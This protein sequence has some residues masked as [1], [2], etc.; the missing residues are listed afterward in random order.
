MSASNIPG[1]SFAALFL[2]TCQSAASVTPAQNCPYH[3]THSM[4]LAMTS[5]DYPLLSVAQK[6]QGSVLLD[7]LVK[8]DGSIADVK[9]AKSSGFALLDGAAVD[10]AGQRWRFDPVMLE[11]KPI[12][13][14]AKVEVVWKLDQSPEELVSAGFALV[15]LSASDFPAGSPALKES[16]AAAIIVLV[17][18]DGTVRDVHCTQSSGFRDLDS[19]AIEAARKGGWRYGA[20]QV[21]GK[22][23]K[24]LVGIVAMWSP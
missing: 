13:C 12:A 9:V 6:E 5:Q 18:E 7:F 4:P 21:G 17:N 22:P 1:T 23:V 10:A 24:S 2:L 20:A 8:P 14:R 15:H 16:G 3:P 19:I 11:G